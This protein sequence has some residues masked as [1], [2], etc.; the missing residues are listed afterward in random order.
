MNQYWTRSFG[1]NNRGGFAENLLLEVG[2]WVQTEGVNTNPASDAETIFLAFSFFDSSGV[3]IFGTDVVVPL[4]QEQATVDT[5]TEIKSDP[6][7]LPVRADSVL[8]AFKFGEQATGTAWVDDVFLRKVDPNAPG[9]EGDIWNNSFNAPEGWFYWWMN[10]PR[11]E[12]PIIATVSNEDAHSGS[13]SL[14]I[15]E[16]D[17]DND[18]VVFISDFIPINPNQNYLLSAFVKTV[19]FSAD[20]SLVNEGYRIGFTV[21]WHRGNVGWTE[22]RGEDFKFDIRSAD[23]DWKQYAMPLTPPTEAHYVSVRA[24]YFNFATGTSFWDDFSLSPLMVTAVESAGEVSGPRGTQ[25]TKFD[26]AQNYPNPFNPSTTIEYRV[27]TSTHVKVE[28]YNL[29]GQKVRTLIDAPHVQGTYRVQWNGLDDLGR[30]VST[31]IYLYRLQT[32][33]QAFVRKM[34]LIK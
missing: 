4:P 32:G 33:D 9:W 21:T 7:T 22:I 1:A 10:F 27:P 2:G 16:N 6:F 5:W 23:T 15:I 31:G 29:L 34:T 14:K 17:N 30:S 3:K 28:I 12:I 19:G 20:S 24:R 18:E 26:L 13:Q 25:P 8:I 11:G